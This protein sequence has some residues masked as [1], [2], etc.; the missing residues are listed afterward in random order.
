MNEIGNKDGE[1]LLSVKQL[2]AR[3]GVCRETVRRN[4]G[5][6]RVMVGRKLIRYRASDI[7]AIEAQMAEIAF[8][9][10]GA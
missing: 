7:E 6:R 8:K 4:R 2:A 3:W 1:R 9:K 5:L 10:E